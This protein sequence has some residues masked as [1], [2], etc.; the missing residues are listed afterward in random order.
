MKKIS[1]MLLV[2]GMAVSL[3]ACGSGKDT[4]NPSASKGNERETGSG[5]N[6][7][8]AKDTMVIVVNGDH[9]NVNMADSIGN[10]SSMLNSLCTNHLVDFYYNEDGSVQHGICDRSLASSYEYGEDN[11]GM[12]FHL[13]EGVL[14][15]NGEEL[16]AEDVI[17]SL[18]F[19]KNKTGYDWI[20]FD[21]LKAVDDYTVYIPFHYIYSSS[22][23]QLCV[24]GMWNYDYWEEVGGNET[25][26]F[27]DAPIGTGAWQITEYETDNYVNL[28]RFEQYFEGPAILSNLTVRF[29]SE[30]TV[31]FSELITGGAD[32]VFT[33]A[34]SDI[35]DVESGVYKD[36]I[37][38]FNA[39]KED[40]LMIGFNGYSEYL[41]DINVRKA[42]CHAFNR[43]DM[44][45]VYNGAAIDM[46]TVTTNAPG[47]MKDYSD[48]W[49]YEYNPETA[50]QCLKD[51]GW[52]DTDGDGLVENAAG[53]E[54]HLRYL[55]IGSSAAYATI[56]EIMKNNLAA[57]GIDLELCGY[58]IP[59]YE[60]MMAN[61]VEGWDFWE[62]QLGSI[63]S[64]NGWNYT[65]EVEML[66]KAHSDQ[67]D[68]WKDYQEKYIK[69]LNETLDTEAWW[70]LFRELEPKTMTDYLYWYPICQPRDVSAYSSKLKGFERI[71]WQTWNLADCYFTE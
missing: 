60:D 63:N 31:A 34:G 38:L 30:S 5:D 21:N 46:Y 45:A 57:V 61:D 68:T 11:M 69:P 66:D 19:Y 37:S 53:E 49:F 48:H 24:V 64:A 13:R 54:I 17:F 36:E 52:E 58:D 4:K 44:T 70:T 20:D 65:Y 47:T 14:F 51:A 3:T 50:A 41:Q 67:F 32:Y 16:T 9:G 12:T 15:Q 35:N 55:Y 39:L 23:I 28:V 71:T 42:I 18:G 43:E 7:T 26:F 27:H 22:L 29:I 56:G 25:L 40:A 33:P 62:M 59:T 1:T 8:S 2:L 6:I 10:N